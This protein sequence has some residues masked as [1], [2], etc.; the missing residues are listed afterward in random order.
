MIDAVERK[1]LACEIRYMVGWWVYVG[2]V[3]IWWVY[4][5]YMVGI[6]WNGIWWVWSIDDIPSLWRGGIFEQRG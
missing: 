2:M 3:G 1:G 5:G 6:W 4:V